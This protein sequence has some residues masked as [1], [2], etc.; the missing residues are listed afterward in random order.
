MTVAP[1]V[2]FG[3]IAGAAV[4]RWNREVSSTQCEVLMTPPMMSTR[5]DQAITPFAIRWVAR[6]IAAEI[7]WL[8]S[9]D[10][11]RHAQRR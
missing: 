5:N 6:R 4:I 8:A 2:Q 1:M 11:G 10:Y 9:T 3:L 7:P